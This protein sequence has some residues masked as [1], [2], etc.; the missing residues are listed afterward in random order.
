MASNGFWVAYY[1]A[2]ISDPAGNSGFT[3]CTGD[4][5]TW[6]GF[7]GTSISSPI[8]AGIQALVNQST[9]SSWGNSN[10]VLYALA[11]QAYG[12]A[13][14]SSCNSSLGNGVSSSCVFYDVTQGDMAVNCTGTHNCYI[15]GGTYGVLST[16]NTAL[17]PAYGTG[18]GYDF[19]TGIGTTNVT[20]LVNAWKAYASTTY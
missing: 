18:V 11:R 2:C 15:N 17:Q 10:P 3:P 20:N 16:S 12:S 6:A 7:G 8:W 4:P 14:S 5:S 1:A 13:G 19:A 9:G